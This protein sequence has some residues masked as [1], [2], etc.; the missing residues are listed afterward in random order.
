MALTPTLIAVPA[1][2]SIPPMTSDTVSKKPT[3]PSM[4]SD[5]SERVAVISSVTALVT[6]STLGGINDLPF[7][8]L[9]VPPPSRGVGV[10]NGVDDGSGSVES[11]VDGVTGDVYGVVDRFNGFLDGACDGGAELIG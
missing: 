11:V 8:P 1:I 6:A 9:T 7:L 10:W 3:M 4:I 5:G 2:L